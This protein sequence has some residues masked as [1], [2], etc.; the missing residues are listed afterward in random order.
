MLTHADVFYVDAD[1]CYADAGARGDAR[2][3]QRSAPQL[4]VAHCGIQGGAYSQRGLKPA[5]FDGWQTG[6]HATGATDGDGSGIWSCDTLQQLSP[7][8]KAERGLEGLG[9]GGGGG[10]SVTA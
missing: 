9:G 6:C 8:G 1:V 10:A 5:P 3:H 7:R 2:E 4:D